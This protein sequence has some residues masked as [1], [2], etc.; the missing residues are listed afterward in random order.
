MPILVPTPP[1]FPPPMHLLAARQ[2][3]DEYEE[4]FCED[5]GIEVD[6]EPFI[7]PSEWNKPKL[8]PWAKSHAK[9]K[10]LIDGDTV[11]FVPS[12]MKQWRGEVKIMKEAECTEALGVTNAVK[13]SVMKRWHRE[14]MKEDE[15]VETPP[16]SDVSKSVKTPVVKPTCGKIKKHTKLDG[17]VETP[18]VGKTVKKLIIKP[19]CAPK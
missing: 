5:L 7:P 18:A 19:T 4:I 10:V 9:K 12:V 15:L 1:P 2:V 6:L 17:L 3:V 14:I 16:D 11:K 13:T 8:C